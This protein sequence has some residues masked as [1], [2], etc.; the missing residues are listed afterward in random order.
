M[1]QVGPGLIETSFYHANILNALTVDLLN[2]FLQVSYVVTLPHIINQMLNRTD[3]RNNTIIVS[4]SV[5]MGWLLIYY[6]G[7]TISRVCLIVI[8]ND[9]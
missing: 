9:S 3:N 7:F 8:L 4:L 6:D 5:R 1:F 2:Y